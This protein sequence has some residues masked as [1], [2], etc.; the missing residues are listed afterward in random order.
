MLRSFR[1]A[2]ERL[3]KREV[4]SAVPLVTHELLQPLAMTAG[5]EIT[6]TTDKASVSADRSH[7]DNLSESGE[8]KQAKIAQAVA[9]DAVFEQWANTGLTVDHSVVSTEESMVRTGNEPQQLIAILIGMA[10]SRSSGEATDPRDQS[11]NSIAI[12]QDQI[13]TST[14]ADLTNSLVGQDQETG[15]LVVWGSVFNFGTSSST[16]D[17]RESTHNFA[18]WGAEEF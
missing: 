5:D 15:E 9:H 7:S 17:R 16:Q 3:E 2:F 18:W 1:P 8:E 10:K 14:G 13:S 4:F 12:N 11:G 6:L